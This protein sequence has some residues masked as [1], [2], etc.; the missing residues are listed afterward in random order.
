MCVL[1]T[2]SVFLN[3]FNFYDNV[4]ISSIK[5]LLPVTENCT[6]YSLIHLHGLLTHLFIVMQLEQQMGGQLQ[7][8]TQKSRIVLTAQ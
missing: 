2:H 3:S 8:G 7:L 5:Q 1:S 6:T 4:I